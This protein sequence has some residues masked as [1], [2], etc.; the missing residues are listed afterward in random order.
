[1]PVPVTPSAVAAV[2]PSTWKLVSVLF[3]VSFRYLPLPSSEAVTAPL[4]PSP[5]VLLI[6]EMMV[7]MFCGVGDDGLCTVYVVAPTW[8][9]RLLTSVVK[10]PEVSTLPVT[11]PSASPP[12]PVLPVTTI[13]S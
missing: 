1:M 7:L 8:I 2:E 10:P 4:G 11:V 5:A 9:C 12:M 6:S 13:G 3:A